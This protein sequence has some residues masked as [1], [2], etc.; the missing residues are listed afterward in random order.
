MRLQL[1][2]LLETNDELNT[3]GVYFTEVRRRFYKNY[4]NHYEGEVSIQII[5]LHGK[6]NYK[7]NKIKQ[8]IKNQI[9]AN[10]SYDVHTVVILCID[11]D[12]TKQNFEPGSFFY[13]VREYCQKYNY[14]LVWYCK[15]VE[16]VFLGKEA[17]EVHKVEAAKEF[18]RTERIYEIKESNLSQTIIKYGYSNILLILDKYLIRN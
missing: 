7:S 8:R 18:A 10:K 9:A 16:N 5:P 3:D 17:N 14:E 13:N 12:S 11:T 15:N 4:S 6:Q 2:V 1:L